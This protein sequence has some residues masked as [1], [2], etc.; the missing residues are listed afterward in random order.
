MK[1][2][3][4]K[5][6]ITII[7][8][9][10]EDEINDYLELDDSIINDIINNKNNN[11]DYIDNTVYIIQYPEGILS[12][13][14]GIIKN[15]YEDKR[16]NFIH[17]CCTKR[18]SSGSPILSVNNKVIGIHKSEKGNNNLGTFLNYPIKEFIKKYSNKTKINTK[19][20]LIGLKNIEAP[21]YMNPILQCLSNSKNL[22]NYFLTKYKEDPKKNNGK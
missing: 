3:N 22:T 11:D 5:Y 4:E 2:T 9:K 16:F 18:G 1:Y 13:S 8:L 7:E 10:K 14:F 12:V 21:C 20:G 6:D 15:I 19:E 17:K